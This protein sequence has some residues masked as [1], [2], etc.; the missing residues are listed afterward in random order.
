M[1]QCMQYVKLPNVDDILTDGS[2]FLAEE[3]T[4]TAPRIASKTP[5]K[6]CFLNVSSRSIGARIVLE[7]SVMVPN[8]AMIDAGA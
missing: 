4:M 6:S 5:T 1:Y 7:T 3:T 2:W 8:G